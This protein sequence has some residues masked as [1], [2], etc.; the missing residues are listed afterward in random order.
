M[1]NLVELMADGDECAFD[2]PCLHGHHVKGHAIYCHNREWK[3]SPR[4]CRRGPFSFEG[5]TFDG[6]PGYCANTAEAVS[7]FFK[8]N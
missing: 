1:V 8:D 7:D 3:H 5:V 6:C 4:K 2:T